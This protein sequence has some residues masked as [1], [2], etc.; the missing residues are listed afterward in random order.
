MSEQ[1]TE[2]HRFN[3]QARQLWPARA[4]ISLQS[5][6][7]HSKKYL[8]RLPHYITK[9]P[10]GSCILEREIGRLHPY[11]GR[12]FNFNKAYWTP[13]SPRE[14]YE[15]GCKQ[16]K[17]QLGLPLQDGEVIALAQF[18]G[19]RFHRIIDQFRSIIGLV[20]NP[21]VRPALRL[22]F[23]GYEEGGL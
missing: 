3:A 23:L 7:M 12:I 20:A 10:I 9:F 6:T 5:H 18:T 15:L 19:T 8:G 1:R 16:I 11:E 4:S 17:E 21:L 22:P 13:L 2:I 14:A